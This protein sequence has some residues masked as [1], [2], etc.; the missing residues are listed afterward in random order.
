MA[1]VQIPRAMSAVSPV[2]TPGRIPNLP[3]IEHPMSRLGDRNDLAVRGSSTYGGRRDDLTPRGLQRSNTDIGSRKREIAD[4]SK[5]SP[6]R[7]LNWPPG[8]QVIFPL[9]L[10]I[11]TLL[12][13]TIMCEYCHLH[14]K[15]LKFL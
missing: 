13:F 14:V 5:K 6:D 12:F 15:L 11:I 4:A 1:T 2:G 8:T 9:Y 10:V 7:I 3:V